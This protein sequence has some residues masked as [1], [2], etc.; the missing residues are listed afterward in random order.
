MPGDR[1]KP[2]GK[3]EVPLTREDRQTLFRGTLLRRHY[4]DEEDARQAG[5]LPKKALP[6]DNS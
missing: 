4:Q 2:K 1:S 6:K 3:K 5:A